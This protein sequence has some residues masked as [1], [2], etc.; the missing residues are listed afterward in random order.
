M[1]KYR[2]DHKRVLEGSESTTIA[3]IV[4][5]VNEKY[6]HLPKINLVYEDNGEKFVL[7]DFNIMMEESKD[8]AVI[9]NVLLKERYGVYCV[10]L[11]IEVAAISPIAERCFEDS[12][13]F[14]V[15][16]SVFYSTGIVSPYAAACVLLPQKFAPYLVVVGSLICVVIT[17][18]NFRGILGLKWVCEKAVNGARWIRSWIFSTFTRD[19]QG[20]PI[21]NEA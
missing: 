10:R 3:D 13:K 17:L 5:F 1:V 6:P 4:G 12:R 21:T 2:D 8:A 18:Y 11:G 9:I 15:F 7:D 16:K 20:L 19:G 14:R